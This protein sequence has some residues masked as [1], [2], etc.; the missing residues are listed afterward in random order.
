MSA[1]AGQVWPSPSDPSA[2]VDPSWDQQAPGNFPPIG[3][4]TSKGMNQPKMI[5]SSCIV[6]SKN[7]ELT[8][9][10]SRTL[11]AR[12]WGWGKRR[13]WSRVRIS[14]FK[15]NRFGGANVQHGGYRQQYCTVH[16]KVAMRVASNRSHNNNNGTCVR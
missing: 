5:Q 7:A 10:K 2:V 12:R 4:F 3:V 13:C 9:T 11:V 8:E 14:N 1:L 6:D 15:R 16:L